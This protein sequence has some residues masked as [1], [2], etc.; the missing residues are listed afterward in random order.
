[1]IEITTRDPRFGNGVKLPSEGFR[2]G[3]GKIMIYDLIPKFRSTMGTERRRQESN[4][5]LAVLQT[6]AFASSPLRHIGSNVSYKSILPFSIELL[7]FFLD[8]RRNQL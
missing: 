7:N 5:C 4:L 8:T 3:M 1:M 2:C 6:A